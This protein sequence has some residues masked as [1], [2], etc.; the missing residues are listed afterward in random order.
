MQQN[1]DA[2]ELQCIGNMATKDNTSTQMEDMAIIELKD[3]LR[4]RKMQTTGIK[5]D[6]IKCLQAIMIVGKQK[7]DDFSND[8]NDEEK[9]N[10]DS[11]NETDNEH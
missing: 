10:Q 9:E 6:L 11:E 8:D 1:Y 3:E 5:A 4:R 7:D 2:T